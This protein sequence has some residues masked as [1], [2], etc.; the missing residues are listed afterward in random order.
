MSFTV[1]HVALT[2]SSISPLLFC[3]SFQY[4]SGIIFRDFFLQLGWNHAFMSCLI[5]PAILCLIENLSQNSLFYKSV[6]FFLYFLSFFFNIYKKLSQQK[7]N[8][9]PFVSHSIF[10]NESD[11]I[12]FKIKTIMIIWIRYINKKLYF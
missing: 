7:M 6:G 3:C 11:D 4:C 9:K 1:Y 2:A 5:W 8:V 12:I 10:F